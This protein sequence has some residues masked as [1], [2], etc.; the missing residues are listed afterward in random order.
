MTFS[1]NLVCVVALC[2]LAATALCLSPANAAASPDPDSSAGA[3]GKPCPLPTLAMAPAPGSGS[4]PPKLALATSVAPADTSTSSVIRPDPKEQITCGKVGVRT[5]SDIVFAEHTLR[6]GKPLQLHMDVQV[7]APKGNRRPLVVYVPGG[8]FILSAK[9]SALNLRTYVAEAGFVVASIQY[10]TV[11]VGANYRDGISD[12]K[13]AVRYLR[14][15]AEQFGIDPRKVA[16]WGESAGGYLAAMVG[17]TNGDPSFEAG[18]DLHQSSAVQAVV[19]KFG[20]SDMTRIAS[21]FDAQ[22]QAN[23]T[24]ENAIMAYVGADV[25]TAANPLHYIKSDHPPF[26]IFHGSDDRLVSPSQTLLLHNALRAAG[27]HSTRYVLD[28]AGHGDMS[29]MGDFQSGLPWSS[30]Q[31]MGI[32]VDF[33]Q[34]T[35]GSRPG[36]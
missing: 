12:V 14:A 6:S 35:I 15:N 26:L 25:S 1:L 31:T 16:V 13:S 28:G 3:G 34:Q 36:S 22:T 29:F 2:L 17:V 19:D 27:V 20:T 8:G 4:P 10:R 9:E 18:P 30:R 21:D 11:S 24:N 23:Y 5:F 7:P 32:V 33:L